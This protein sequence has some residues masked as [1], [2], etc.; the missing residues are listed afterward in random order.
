MKLNPS[1]QTCNSEVSGARSGAPLIV[2][3][4]ILKQD[5][6][7]M[8]NT[9]VLLRSKTVICTPCQIFIELK[10]LFQYPGEGTD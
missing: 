4:E 9:A 5:P 2:S 1:L 6:M 10:P 3:I 8:S 7:V